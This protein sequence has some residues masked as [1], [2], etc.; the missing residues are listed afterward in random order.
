MRKPLVAL[1]VLV[2]LDR[3]RKPR[4]TAPPVP[5]VPDQATGA[6]TPVA[7]GTPVPV[8]PTTQK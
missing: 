6:F 5:H 2:F 1:L 8:P 3:D 7:P 4:P